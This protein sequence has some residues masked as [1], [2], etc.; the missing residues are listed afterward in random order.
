MFDHLFAI[1]TAGRFMAAVSVR[2]EV[3]KRTMIGG[4]RMLI[5]G[6]AA[7][8]ELAGHTPDVVQHVALH[9][10]DRV[11]CIVPF[12]IPMIT[13][14]D[15]LLGLQILV[16]AGL[17]IVLYHVLFIAVDLRKVMR[18]VDTVTR[19][20]EKIVMKPVSVADQILEFAVSAIEGSKEGKKKGGKKHEKK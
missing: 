19:E 10:F 2:I 6:D 14:D 7:D 12:P 16:F 15:L 9:T 5:H 3:S 13:A 8:N 18:R 4:K 1:L 17:V 20:I 11:P